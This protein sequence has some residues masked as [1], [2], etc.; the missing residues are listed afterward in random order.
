MG[1]GERSPLAEPKNK[2]QSHSFVPF[3]K[4]RKK[5][6]ISVS[7]TTLSSPSLNI[8]EGDEPLWNAGIKPGHLDLS[9]ALR[10]GW[11]R[12]EIWGGGSRERLKRECGHES[13]GLHNHRECQHS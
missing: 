10:R 3:W 2:E 7:L 4:E 11:P 12:V 8:R 5:M 13:K 1:I 9:P 6:K